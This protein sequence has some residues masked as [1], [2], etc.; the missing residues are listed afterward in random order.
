MSAAS[1]ADLLARRLTLVAQLSHTTSLVQKLRQSRAGAEMDV[2]RCELGLGDQ[3]PAKMARDLL[4]AR[5]RVSEAD[6]GLDSCDAEI[7]TLEESL[8][9][10][11][12]A[13][14]QYSKVSAPGRTM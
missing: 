11:D 5:A 8:A 1:L 2:M 6:R 12:A 7:V 9:E 14:E 3:S 10:T 4:D 13:I